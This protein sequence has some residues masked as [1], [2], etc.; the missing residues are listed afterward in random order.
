M[1]AI[2]SMLLFCRQMHKPFSMA[3]RTFVDSNLKVAG[4]KC[5]KWNLNEPLPNH[6]THTSHTSISIELAEKFDTSQATAMPL[7]DFD[8]VFWLFYSPILFRLCHESYSAILALHCNSKTACRV[9]FRIVHAKRVKAFSLCSFSTNARGWHWSK[10]K[11]R[12]SEKKKQN[13]TGK[14]STFICRVTKQRWWIWRSQ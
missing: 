3:F 6:G 14:R 7:L 4:K 13:F 1:H 11:R 2:K 5:C 9:L 12:F 8:L 10:A